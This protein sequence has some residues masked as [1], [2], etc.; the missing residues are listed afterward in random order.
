VDQQVGRELRVRVGRLRRHADVELAGQRPAAR[1]NE[2]HAAR[3]K[4]GRD[5]AQVE[6]HPGDAGD[7]LGGLAERLEAADP[8]GAA[9][10]GE[11]ELLAV[12]DRAGGQGAR[13][14]GAR[15][16]DRERAVD[17]E[18]D[19]G[20][21]SGRGLA[22]GVHQ[23]D[24]G[25]P[26]VIEPLTG[27]RADADRLD[28]AKARPGD[29]GAGLA[30]GGCR[31]GQVGAGDD[32]QAVADAE[33]V[34]GGQ[35]LGG[36][37]HPAAVGRDDEHDGG[38]WSKA[39]EH[40][41]HEALVPRDVDER[42]LVPRGQCHPGVAEVDGHA[43]AAFLRPAVGLHPGKRADQR[44]LAVVD[45]PCGRDDVHQTPSPLGSPFPLAARTAVM[46]RSSS[47]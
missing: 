36:L 42:Q 18:P 20:G 47:S 25:G 33:G 26:E 24:E 39:G 8:D 14:D 9:R 21:T 1:L 22:E 7:R 2:G 15:A 41:R 6:R 19:R 40:V 30:G 45:V 38:D 13:D 27:H 10:G 34:D 35:V 44:G 46:R 3:G 11:R 12:P 4:V 37:R 23:A 16:L 29:L 31:V 28:G 17:P 5:A 43:A 32:Q